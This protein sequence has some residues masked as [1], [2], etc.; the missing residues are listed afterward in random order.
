MTDFE[1][2]ITVSSY[3]YFLS[4]VICLIIGV[5][6]FF[7]RNMAMKFRI[8]TRGD[9]IGHILASVTPVLN[10]V[11]VINSIETFVNVVMNSKFLNDPL[12]KELR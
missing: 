5:M 6:A 11:L 7:N 4:A 10:I 3:V 2:I 8:R 12:H 9:F 1:Q